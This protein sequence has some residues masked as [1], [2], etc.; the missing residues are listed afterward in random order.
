MSSERPLSERPA[1]RPAKPAKPA[2]S[3]TPSAEPPQATPPAQQS[4]GPGCLVWILILIAAVALIGIFSSMASGGS[5]SDSVEYGTCTGKRLDS[6]SK[7]K[8]E[9]I[10]KFGEVV[11]E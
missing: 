1:A 9:A 4:Q 3:D 10:C 7:I 11:G 8:A 5:N 6:D 2:N